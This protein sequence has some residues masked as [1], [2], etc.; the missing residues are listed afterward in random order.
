MRVSKGTSRGHMHTS[1]GASEGMPCTQCAH[2]AHEV[3]SF[4]CRPILRPYFWPLFTSFW[5]H[6]GFFF[7]FLC[8]WDVAH[9][10]CHP[11]LPNVNHFYPFSIPYI[12]LSPLLGP[13]EGRGDVAIHSPRT[14]RSLW[15][16]LHPH[17]ITDLARHQQVCRVYAQ[18]HH[19]PPLHPTSRSPSPKRPRLQERSHRHRNTRSKRTLQG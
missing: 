17:H 2:S 14:L 8:I 10:N 6:T 9:L 13:R 4:E 5:F 3:R 16:G 18:N 1:S 12:E 15:Y 11:L 19:R 7:S